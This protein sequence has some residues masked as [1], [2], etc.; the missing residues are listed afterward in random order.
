MSYQTFQEVEQQLA[1]VRQCLAGTTVEEWA[2]AD[3]RID[4]TLPNGVSFS[5]SADFNEGFFLPLCAT[6]QL[7][8]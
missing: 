6:A 2:D 3:A 7:G 4:L 5:L 1:G 8:P